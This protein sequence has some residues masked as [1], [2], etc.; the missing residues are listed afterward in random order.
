MNSIP[1]PPAATATRT[2]SARPAPI[3][4][5]D[6]GSSDDKQDEQ[7]ISSRS[8]GSAVE[9]ASPTSP[10]RKEA[11]RLN[12]KAET[13]KRKRN[14]Y[15]FD[16]GL[17]K[18]GQ[19]L[20]ALPSIT[21]SLSRESSRPPSRAL[22]AQEHNAMS[23]GGIQRGSAESTTAA[24]HNA[25][26]GSKEFTEERSWVPDVGSTGER[27]G[28]GELPHFIS[29]GEG[30][31]S[32]PTATTL[33]DSMNLLP[34]SV[35]TRSSAE[36]SPAI[37]RYASPAVG[38]S[39]NASYHDSLGG[40]GILDP[41]SDGR[42][43]GMGRAVIGVTTDTTGSDFETDEDEVRSSKPLSARTLWPPK[44]ASGHQAGNHTSNSQWPW[45]TRRRTVDLLRDDQPADHRQGHT[46]NSSNEYSPLKRDESE[47][48][49]TGRLDR[50]TPSNSLT[51]SSSS[52]GNPMAGS[53]HSA[54]SQYTDYQSLPTAADDLSLPKTH[55]DSA[56]VAF[57]SE[58]GKHRRGLKQFLSWIKHRVGT[59]A[60]GVVE[61]ANEASQRV[62]GTTGGNVRLPSGSMGGRRRNR[63]R[64]NSKGR[65]DDTLWL[66]NV[67]RL[68][69]TQ[70][71]TIVS[72]GNELWHETLLIG[73]FKLLALISF[74]AFAV[75]LTISLKYLLNPDKAPL[76]WRDYC[77]S[78]HPSYYA[79][80]Y[81][82]NHHPTP[83]EHQVRLSM[84]ENLL[85]MPGASADLLHVIN[86]THS[87][88]P[89]RNQKDLPY[90]AE[91]PDVD[92]LQPVGV[93]IGV[94]TMD[95]GRDRRMLIR[96]TYGIHPKSRV[97]GT[98]GVRIKFVMGQP[99]AGYER[100]VELEMESESRLKI[101]SYCVI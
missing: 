23:S 22:F 63:R 49:L 48:S 88:W 24:Q 33:A 72:F 70:P 57:S 1:P 21:E 28:A 56:S 17:D 99:R 18:D 32:I 91:S 39:S 43:Q 30:S 5:D 98:E 12:K 36:S 47:G 16:L 46:R 69:P 80:Q 53:R 40:S 41:E 89:F 86:S 65:T 9:E 84:E 75:T 34:L 94:F 2:D 20:P 27:S 59:G 42:S 8:W 81:P 71:M 55:L 52:Y 64:Q 35:S 60:S 77:Q 15:S 7:G 83:E 10:S 66:L 97:P 73:D 95:E 19:E 58:L 38:Y 54:H 96:Q 67:L 31:R 29:G 90:S 68:V 26:S 82:P 3:P 78:P 13:S 79:L 6:I 100:S 4:L 101:I 92:L 14:R 44:T 85:T 87:A 50:D 45:R 74:G 51:H 25:R 11:H 76:P 62:A 93:F 61:L 37:S